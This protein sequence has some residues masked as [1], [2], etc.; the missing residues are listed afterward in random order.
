MPVRIYKPITPGRRHSSVNTF[1]ELTKN[2]RPTKK[3]LRAK[4]QNAGRNAQGKITVRH[5][6]G[7]HKRFYRVVDFMQ[8]R[9]D[10]PAEVKSIEYDPNRTTFIALIQYANGD[11]SY[12]LAPHG[13]TVG[14]KLVWSMSRV[15]IKPGNRTALGNI[16]TGMPVH[17]IELTPKAGGAIVRSAGSAATVMAVEGDYA[18][19][20]LPSG[21]IRR[22]LKN[23][24][25]SIGQLSN[26]D[27][28][29]IRWGKAGRMR[30]KSRRP[31]VRGK[32]MN[33]V[34][35]PHGG[36]EGNQPIGMKAPKTPWGKKALGVKTRR[37]K[38]FSNSF[39]I[40]RRR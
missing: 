27:H 18:L 37:K 10:A 39:I 22:V 29:N 6:G 19:L 32:A 8:L 33:P 34:D 2:V 13:L 28:S 30:W 25:A 24:H 38:K 23:C 4:M 40:K 3:L 20:R 16:P 15:E 17:N 1:A 36:G 26:I 21:E 31:S 14:E 7:G 11:K 12:I 5:R 35:H 9:F